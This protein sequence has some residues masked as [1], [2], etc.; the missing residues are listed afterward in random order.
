MESKSAI[1][2][3]EAQ[4]ERELRMTPGERVLRALALGRRACV[5]MAAAKGC[6]VKQAR[7]EAKA[8]V[9]AARTAA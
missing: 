9:R 1:A 2:A 7:E 3:R 6:S 8:V 4:R 5:M